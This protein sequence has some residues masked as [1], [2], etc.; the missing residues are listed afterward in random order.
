MDHFY[1]LC[2]VF[3]VCRSVMSP[4]CSLVVTYWEMAGFLALLCVMF[5]CVLSL[6]LMFA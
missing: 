2:F 5:S 3:R 1:Y 4:P 6:S